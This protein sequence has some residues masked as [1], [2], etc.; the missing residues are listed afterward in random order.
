MAAHIGLHEVGA[1]FESRP[2]GLRKQTQFAA[3]NLEA[4]YQRVLDRAAVRK[5]YEVEAAIGYD[6]RNFTPPKL[7]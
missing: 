3:F 1:E 7:P 2:V 4:H 6:L 5:T